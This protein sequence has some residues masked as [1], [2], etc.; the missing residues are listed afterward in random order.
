MRIFKP[1]TNLFCFGGGLI[2]DGTPIDDI[3]KPAR[4]SF[5]HR[6]WRQST[7]DQPDSHD[8]GLAEPGRQIER[9]GN[10]ACAKSQKQPLLPR[11]RIVALKRGK[12]L[13][14]SR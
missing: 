6:F 13:S 1:A 8:R 12:L 14:E 4:D 3:G 7:C 5:S 10:L 2:D 9:G 11:K